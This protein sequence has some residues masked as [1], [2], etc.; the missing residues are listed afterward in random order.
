MKELKG[1]EIFDISNNVEINEDIYLK[2]RTSAPIFEA[3]SS[4]F[5]HSTYIMDFREKE[6]LFV[7]SNKLFLSGYNKKEVLE[8][9][10]LF[11]LDVIPKQDL[12]K[13]LHFLKCGSEFYHNLAIEK[14]FDYILE[15][16]FELLDIT[17]L[18]RKRVCQKMTPLHIDNDGSICLVLCVLFLSVSKNNNNTAIIRHRDLPEQ[19]RLS[20]NENH[21]K[22]I[23]IEELN[24]KEIQVLQLTA[25]GFTNKTIAEK[26][27]L[28]INTIKYH[29]KN[30]C[31]KLNANTCVEALSI[32]AHFGYL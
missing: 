30:I 11:F 22:K 2:I 26:L 8:K 28:N 3:V 23:S 12:T 14:R 15:F 25:Q 20:Q 4:V 17:K 1:L 21:W 5:N 24:F 16:E 13:V 10:F 27:A 31:Q 6:F 19:Y 18:K 32:A 7:S 9:G 29:K